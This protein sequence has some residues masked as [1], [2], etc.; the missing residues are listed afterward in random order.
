MMQNRIAKTTFWKII[1]LNISYHSDTYWN[2]IGAKIVEFDQTIAT[3]AKKKNRNTLDDFCRISEARAVQ[4][5]AKLVEFE[6]DLVISFNEKE[7]NQEG[8]INNGCYIFSKKV[9]ESYSGRFSIE[10][11]VFPTL[12][13]KKELYVYK[14]PGTFIY[15]GIPEDYNRLLKEKNGN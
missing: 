12:A 14:A 3:F 8:W 11:D 5:N 15:I 2:K 6:N 7:N 1:I 10:V 9:F 4:R 13:K